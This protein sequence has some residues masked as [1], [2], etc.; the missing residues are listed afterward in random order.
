MERRLL[1]NWILGPRDE[2]TCW[3]YWVPDNL[4]KDGI[5]WSLHNNN[6]MRL[7]DVSEFGNYAYVPSVSSR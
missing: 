3:P 6:D 1:G 2:L 5:F 4:R 7:P